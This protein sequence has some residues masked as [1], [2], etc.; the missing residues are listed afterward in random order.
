MF[1]TL[2]VFVTFI[3]AFFAPTVALAQSAGSTNSAQV[4]FIAT[5]ENEWVMSPPSGCDTNSLCLEVR[6]TTQW[7]LQP[8]L[9]G[10][11]MKPAVMQL[12]NNNGYETRMA[13]GLWISPTEFV[14]CIPS[15]KSAWTILATPRV[16]LS[17]TTYSGAVPESSKTIS[18]VSGVPVFSLNHMAI[19][20]AGPATVVG[21]AAGNC[22]SMAHIMKDSTLWSRRSEFNLGRCPT[23]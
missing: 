8:N 11:G 1:R 10:S 16:Q 12:V 13:I 17:G 20:A 7:C 19:T 9:D 23:R 4:L 6:N 5:V 15:G 14:S 3:F 22:S 21:R 18:S 2:I